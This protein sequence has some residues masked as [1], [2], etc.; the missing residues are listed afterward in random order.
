MKAVFSKEKGKVVV[1]EISVPEIRDGELLVKMMACGICGSD[2][3]KV[4]GDYGMGS[5][6]IGHEISG[7]IAKSK[8]KEFSVG[9]R[10]FVRQRVPCYKC[11]YCE[12]G[13][14]TVCDLFQKTNVEPCGLAEYFAVSETHVA[15]GGVTLI[16]EN[17]SFEEA[18]VAEPLSCCIRGIEKTNLQKGNSVV[19]IGAG[20]VG[21]MNA[22]VLKNKGI[23]KILLV[24]INEPRLEFAGKYGRT[25]NSTKEDLEDTVKKETGIGADLVVIAVSNMKVFDQALKIVRKGGK[26]LL[27]GVPPKNSEIRLD[28]NYLFSNQI[29]IITSVYSVKKEVEAALNLI[30]AG[31][32]DVKQ[33]IT[34][35]FAIQDSQRAFELAHKAEN[36]MKIVIT[37]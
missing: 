11:H 26:I 19:I 2:V 16:P 9:Q 35:R 21:I 3:E 27:F 32:V 31:K 33:L 15:N 29:S 5:K 20:P 14:H 30:S 1:E 28:A 34:H 7:E 6:R 10:V 22:L 13:D 25:I 36:A 4:F 24:D 37:S 18:A 23:E 8:N 12:L 17:V